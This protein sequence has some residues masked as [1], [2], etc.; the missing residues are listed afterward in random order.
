MT[1]QLY[2]KSDND[3]GEKNGFVESWDEL[4]NDPIWQNTCLYEQKS[5][6]MRCLGTGQVRAKSSGSGTF[7]DSVWESLFESIDVENQLCKDNLFLNSSFPTPQSHTTDDFTSFTETPKICNKRLNVWS[8]SSPNS[9]TSTDV[10]VKDD[11][12]STSPDHVWS[13]LF[14]AVDREQVIITELDEYILMNVSGNEPVP[15]ISDTDKTQDHPET[16]E[17]S[18]SSVN[19]NTIIIESEGSKDSASSRS[20]DLAGW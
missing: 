5:T 6:S 17:Q 7:E 1:G 20:M 2:K 19:T 4:M 14:E 18:N 13:E 15:E 10:G 12:I 16:P 9:S 11:A 3:L 8:V